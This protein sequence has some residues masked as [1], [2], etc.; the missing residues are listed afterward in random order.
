MLLLSVQKDF[1]LR[2]TVMFKVERILLVAAVV[3]V[4]IDT[5][6]HK[7]SRKLTRKQVLL[8]EI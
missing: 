7:T 4:V 6:N 5:A 3:S 2:Q 8:A 1:D